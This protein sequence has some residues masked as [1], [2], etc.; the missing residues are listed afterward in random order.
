MNSS[1]TVSI[2]VPVYN[3]ER[4]IKAC[5]DSI[6][7]QSVMPDEVILVN[8]NCTDRTVELAKNYDFVRIIEEKKQGRGHARSAGFTAAVSDVIGRIDADSQLDENWV[9]RLKEK[10]SNDEELAGLTGLGKTSFI[11]GVQSV[12]TTFFTRSYYWLVHAAFRTVT[13][14]GANMALRRSAWNKVVDKVCNDDGTVHEDQ[15]VS[16]WLAAEG[17]KIEQDNK[18]L[19][20]T[21]GQSYRYLPKFFHYYKLFISTRKLHN[22]NGNLQKVSY[23]LGLLQTMP[24]RL[25]S[26]VIG[27]FL[28]LFS[29]AIFP[30]DYFMTKHMQ[31]QDWLE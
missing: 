15:D 12:R 28:L 2:V 3:E 29:V 11:P 16:L 8:N 14:W 1:C 20:T 22:K 25:A 23:R 24:G 10:F 13:M 30:I 19:I 26:F 4:R 31:N 21:S 18:L 5:L 9:A 7:R 6:A 17:G 27:L